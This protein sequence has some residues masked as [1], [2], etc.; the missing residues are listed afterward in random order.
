MEQKLPYRKGQDLF[1]V[2][3]NHYAEI[4]TEEAGPNF[5]CNDGIRSMRR[6]ST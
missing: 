4:V 1:V 5:V 6:E 3:Y 2:A